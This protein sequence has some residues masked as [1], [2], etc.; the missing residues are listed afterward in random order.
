MIYR[1]FTDT[2]IAKLHPITEIE[3]KYAKDKV[4]GYDFTTPNPEYGHLYDNSVPKEY[5]D[6]VFKLMEG[7]LCNYYKYQKDNIYHINTRL[8]E[9]DFTIP[10]SSL[11]HILG[12]EREIISP[13]SLKTKGFFNKVVPGFADTKNPLKKFELI[14]MHKDKI[15]KAE[16][17]LLKDKDILNYR[18]MYIK[19]SSYINFKELDKNTFAL[20]KKNF[21]NHAD[22]KDKI[23]YTIVTKTKQRDK[24]NLASIQLVCQNI[25]EPLIP[26]SMLRNNDVLSYGGSLTLTNDT[27]V[28]KGKLLTNNKNNDRNNKLNTLKNMK[29]QAQKPKKE[30]NK[31]EVSRSRDKQK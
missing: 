22:P 24:E 3:M 18:K 28:K 14:L 9:A 11:P 6:L 30:M 19:L 17:E 8:G 12:I 16:K 4:T 13:Q 20:S 10:P 2:E 27:I 29:T 15:Q 7:C 5:K 23:Q 1:E 26:I 21:N 25:K 31:N